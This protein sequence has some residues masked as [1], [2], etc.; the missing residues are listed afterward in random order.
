MAEVL[1]DDVGLAMGRYLRTRPDLFRA[2]RSPIRTIIWVLVALLGVAIAVI[3]IVAPETFIRGGR[4]GVGA[5]TGLGMIL[6]PPF[7]LGLGIVGIVWWSRRWRTPGGGKMSSAVSRPFSTTDPDEVWRVLETATSSNDP[8]LVDVLRRLAQEP[9]QGGDWSL[10]V[11]HSPEDRILVAM[12]TRQVLKKPGDPQSGVRSQ[13]EREPVVRRDDAFI[14]LQAAS[15]AAL[16][17]T[18]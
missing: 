2:E 16:Q 4:E 9:S 17:T 12:V 10:T 18:L 15:L 6:V 1:I 7:F 5:R 14:D 13:L 3:A 8:A 11:M